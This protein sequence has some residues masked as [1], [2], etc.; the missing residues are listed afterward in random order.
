MA[1]LGRLRGRRF[2]VIGRAGMDLYADPVGTPVE[3]AGRFV[4][5]LGGSAANIA[6]GLVRQGCDAALVTRL[7]A[8]AVGRFCLNQL[9][10]YGINRDHVRTVAGEPRSSLAVVD[11]RGE[12]TQAVIYRNNAADFALTV[13]DVEAVDFA[14][15]SALIL[16][17]TAL[18]MDPS[19]TAT[20]RAMDL[21]RSRGVPIILDA[22]YRPYSW[23]DERTATEV[24]ERAAAQSDVVV[25]NDVEFAVLAGHP[26][27]GLE[28]A[29]LLVAHGVQ[30]AVYKMGAKGA[31]TLTPGTEVATG[32]F[33]T[34][35]LKP[36]GAGD[37]FLAG[38]VAGLAEG[39]TIDEAVR[40]GSAAAALVVARVG[41]APAMP[42]RAALDAF[43]AAQGGRDA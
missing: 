25:G 37:A 3:D 34:A 1:D 15:A 20:F 23:T 24:L 8:D 11:T 18:A 26:D 4:A 17:G 33:P 31:V 29:R 36:T 12:A 41:C 10:A 38:F 28:R 19:R 6:A 27:R 32:V 40:R 30:V 2:I 42:D 14:A 9:D 5:A 43:L 39:R 16:T 35:A 22:D 21:A 13:P 7:S